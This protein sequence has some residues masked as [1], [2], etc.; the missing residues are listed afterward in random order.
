MPR[1]ALLA[2]LVIGA[3]TLTPLTCPLRRLAQRMHA[4]RGAGG[5]SP[6]A[7]AD[8]L[9]AMA[10]AFCHLTSC[11]EGQIAEQARAQAAHREVIANVAHDLRMPLAA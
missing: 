3:P 6:A 5:T 9:A 11:I 8:E 1:A 10:T 7:V 4:C 2:T